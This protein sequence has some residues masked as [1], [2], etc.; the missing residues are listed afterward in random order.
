MFTLNVNNDIT[1]TGPNDSIDLVPWL[2]RPTSIRLVAASQISGDT[3]GFAR[4]ELA[5]QQQRRWRARSGADCE[6]KR[7]HI[8]SALSLHRPN[9]SVRISD[10]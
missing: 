3:F 7:E 9:C 5:E 2:A 10:Y 8:R 4:R 1:R 6:L